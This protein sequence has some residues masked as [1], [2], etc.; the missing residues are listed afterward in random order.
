MALHF[1]KSESTI[2]R[3]L[4]EFGI[5]LRSIRYSQINDAELLEKVREILSDPHVNGKNII[6]IESLIIGIMFFFLLKE[7]SL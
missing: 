6:V 7:K 5:R 1:G 4:K 3:R 2:K